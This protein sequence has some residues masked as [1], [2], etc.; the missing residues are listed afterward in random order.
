MKKSPLSKCGARLA[1]MFALL[2]AGT[3]SALAT[4]YATCLTNNAGIISFRLNQTNAEVHVTYN[5]GA[6]VTNLGPLPAGLTVTNLGITGNFKVKVAGSA[7][8]GYVQIS[9]DTDYKYLFAN[10]RGLSINTN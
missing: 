10:P 3:F 5:G 7:P 4:P 8:A 1:P 9:T 6:S 2:A